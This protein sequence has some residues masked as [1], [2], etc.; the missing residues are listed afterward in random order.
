M[1]NLVSTLERERIER[2]TEAK[3]RRLLRQLQKD[4]DDAS[5]WMCGILEASGRAE[6]YS[7]AKAETLLRL[8]QE[9]F[10]DVPAATQRRIL[11]ARND[12]LDRWLDRILDAGT[13][14]AVFRRA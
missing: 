4:F 6:G 10:G 8:L 2:R 1:K 9:R 12:D 13:L 5:R 3:A 14:A 11:A 7:E